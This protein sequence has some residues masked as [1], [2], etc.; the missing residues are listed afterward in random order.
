LGQGWARGLLGGSTGGWETAAQQILYPDDFNGI[1]AA[2]PDPVTFTSYVNAN[3]YEDRNYYFYDESLPWLRR[4]RPGQ[5]D[6]YSGTAF[7]AGKGPVF[8]DAYGQVT[9]TMEEGN[10]LE[11]A[12]GTHSRSCGQW[13]IWEAT[14]GPA[15]DDGYP[16]RLYNKL[17][18][19]INHTVAAYWRENFDLAHIVKRDWSVLGPKLKGKLRI[20]V[21][22][23]DT[24]YLTNA[25]LDF[26]KILKE[27]GSDAEV[28]V[29]THEGL[30]YQHCFNGYMY[31]RAG[32]PLPNAVSRNHYLQMNIPRFA[33]HWVKS[34]PEHA[35]VSSW[36]Y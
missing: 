2:C 5:R 18:G 30:G 13:D 4:P 33:E 31:D 26:H 36:R 7:E 22:G 20:A 9:Q 8:V 28:I 3:I 27:L 17:T 34:S 32:K 19:E 6:H 15:C 23:S 14:F 35:D 21:G 16:C 24:F 29:G 10:H 1:L 25:V 11:L 12:M